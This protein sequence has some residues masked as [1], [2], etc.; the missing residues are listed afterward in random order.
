MKSQKSPAFSTKRCARRCRRAARSFR[1][2][3]L[4]TGSHARRAIPGSFPI[5]GPKTGSPIALRALVETP[6][7]PKLRVV[8][9]GD[10]SKF[11]RDT[12]AALRARVTLV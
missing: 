12:V 2:A 6:H 1:Y 11:D 8:A 7:L 5:C 9:L 10:I 4:S 3:S